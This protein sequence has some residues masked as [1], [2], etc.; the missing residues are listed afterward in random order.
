MIKEVSAMVK[1]RAP[2]PLF[3]SALN[4]RMTGIRKGRAYENGVIERSH[5][6]DEEEFLNNALRWIYLYNI[7]RGTLWKIYERK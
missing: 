6:I 2:I 4:V 3:L 7:K 5:R 1:E